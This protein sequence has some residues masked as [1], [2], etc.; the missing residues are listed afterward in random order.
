MQPTLRASVTSVARMRKRRVV[1]EAHVRRRSGIRG[2]V[3]TSVRGGVARHDRALRGRLPRGGNSSGAAI[4]DRHR[5]DRQAR[6][7]CANLISVIAAVL[8]SAPARLDHARRG[9]AR[10]PSLRIDSAARS[11]RRWKSVLS[12]GSVARRDQYRSASSHAF[13]QAVRL[14]ALAGGGSN[15]SW[16]SCPFWGAKSI[17]SMS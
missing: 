9:R 15:S 10:A 2:P 13:P 17:G 3:A 5:R 8:V 14:S 7:P 16:R 4:R 1:S 12:R 11:L 6:S